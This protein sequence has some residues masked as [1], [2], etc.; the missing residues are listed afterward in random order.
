[1]DIGEA[2]ADKKIMIYEIECL[3]KIA[4]QKTSVTLSRE[5]ITGYKVCKC[6]FI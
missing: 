1:M 5:L 3:T 4:E 2:T 6:N